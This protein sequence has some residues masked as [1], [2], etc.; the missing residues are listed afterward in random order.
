VPT[1]TPQ[2]SSIFCEPYRELLR[3]AAWLHHAAEAGQAK[4]GGYDIKQIRDT[5]EGPLQT[6]CRELLEN[7]RTSAIPPRHRHWEETADLMVKVAIDRAWRDYFGRSWFPGKPRE[8]AVESKDELLKALQAGALRGNPPAELLDLGACAL[9]LVY[10][11]ATDHSALEDVLNLYPIL[12]RGSLQEVAFAPQHSD[13]IERTRRALVAWSVVLLVA[14][15][16]LAVGWLVQHTLVT[17]KIEQF[18]KS[19]PTQPSQ[20]PMT[21]PGR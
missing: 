19:L 13:G 5:Q 12:R 18:Q 15:A 20:S 2:D 3:I 6:Q 14:V 10:Y 9:R 21:K 16:L 11:S 8:A 17:Q 1:F 4:S 7:A